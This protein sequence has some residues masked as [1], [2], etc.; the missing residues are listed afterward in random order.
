MYYPVATLNNLWL[1]IN[2]IILVDDI[3]FA[4][5]EKARKAC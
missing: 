1:V 2:T 3:V 5:S 4:A